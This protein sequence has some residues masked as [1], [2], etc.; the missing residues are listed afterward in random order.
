M[1]AELSG[2]IVGFPTSTNF[3]WP[4]ARMRDVCTL[5]Y[6]KALKAE[7]RRVG[8]IP[9]YGSNG[10]TG[11]HDEPLA[12]GP[13]VILG[14][15]GQGNLGVEWRDGP[16]WVIDTA[17]FVT[18]SKEIDP[19]FFYFFVDFVGLNHLKDGTSNPSL[20]RDTFYLQPIPLPPLR[21]QQSIARCL[22]A[23]DDKI[24]LNRRVNETL[25]AM[26]QAIF[27][28][29]F[30]DFGPVRRK[31]SG[32]TDP[33]AVLGGL[34][35]DEEKATE[36]AELF[37]SE[38]SQDEAPN[39]WSLSVLGD[40]FTLERGLS[41][42][43][44]FLA[45]EGVPMINLG[46][47]LGHGRFSHER[48]KGYVGEYRARHTV[49]NGTLLIANTDMTQDRII[50]GSPYIVEDS[51][52]SQP[53]L[54]SHHVYAARPQSPDAAAWAV[55]FFYHLLEPAFRERAEGFASG[56]TVLALPKDAIERAAFVMPPDRLYRAFLEIIGPLRD[57]QAVNRRECDALAET[58]DYLLPR[59][60]SGEVKVRD[61][62]K[63]L[64]A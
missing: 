54:F 36:V 22:A 9:V 33:V 37:G 32:A 60:M 59:L 20:S 55:F 45:H 14:R 42:K 56:T 31:F 30:V 1:T 41:Y 25:E 62:A 40:Y 16:F 44:N 34:I 39:D 35:P 48:L 53:L 21:E 11:W 28:D 24:L 64:A 58:R 23:L 43:G 19:R 49:T 29:W 27:R 18:F 26:A 50:L 57:R 38:L 63:E 12:N 52:A 2:Q 8:T 51:P 17:Y 4:I 5:N 46:C 3:A 61:V 15:K 10:P 47:F 7:V 13:T 6:G